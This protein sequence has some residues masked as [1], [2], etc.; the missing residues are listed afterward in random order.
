MSSRNAGQD[1][2]PASPNKTRGCLHFHSAF[3]KFSSS[4]RQA[5]KFEL[6]WLLSYS[7]AH[8]ALLHGNEGHLR[9]Q[10]IPNLGELSSVGITSL[11]GQS[12]GGTLL[13]G[14]G[15]SGLLELFPMGSISLLALRDPLLEP[16]LRKVWA[17]RAADTS[18]EPRVC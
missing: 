5:A 18:Q 8:P 3:K 15:T 12:P 10:S 4:L 7:A 16:N 2:V 11:A 6:L 13:W 14:S 1:C 17:L 9:G